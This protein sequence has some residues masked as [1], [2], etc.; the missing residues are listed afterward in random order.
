MVWALF[1]LLTSRRRRPA[2]GGG[3][4]A[5]PTMG[6]CEAS[7]SA[8]R[9]GVYASSSSSSASAEWRRGTG[10]EAANPSMVLR[11]LLENT[12]EKKKEKEKKGDKKNRSGYYYFYGFSWFGS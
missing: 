3:G 9:A 8:G 6:L 5:W 2:G 1:R 10:P 7:M 12:K 11:E 4:G